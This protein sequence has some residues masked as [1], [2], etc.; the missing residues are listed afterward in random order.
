MKKL[1][2]A[3]PDTK[4]ASCLGKTEEHTNTQRARPSH[5]PH[6]YKKLE[7]RDTETHRKY[8]H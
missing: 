4:T 2:V 8:S 6:K 1:G 7:G 3:P 5:K